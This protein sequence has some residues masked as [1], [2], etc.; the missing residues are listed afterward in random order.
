M[1]AQIYNL[2]LHTLEGLNLGKRT[3][4]YVVCKWYK[5]AEGERSGTYENTFL[6][7]IPFYFTSIL[8]INSSLLHI[9][10]LYYA[11]L[12]CFVLVVQYG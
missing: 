3:S 2:F 4:M 5:R 12:V 8:Y 10:G 6:V 7:D 1:N 11:F 9:C